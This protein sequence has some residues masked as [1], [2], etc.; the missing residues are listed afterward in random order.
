M[1]WLWMFVRF[2]CVLMLVLVG[3]D[4]KCISSS[5]ISVMLNEVKLISMMFFRL[6]YCIS[7]VVFSG[8]IIVDL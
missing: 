6:I 1:I 5:V 7:S 3:I 8:I 2:G 4:G